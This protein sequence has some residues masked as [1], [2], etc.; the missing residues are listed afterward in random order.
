M[1]IVISILAA[2]IIGII[3]I[4]KIF[5]NIFFYPRDIFMDY[6]DLKK[7][8][9]IWKHLSYFLP[10]LDFLR[11]PVLYYSLILLEVQAHL[12]LAISILIALWIIN[13]LKDLFYGRGMGIFLGVFL[14]VNIEIFKMVTLIYISLLFLSRYQSVASFLT[15]VTATFAV[16][17][18]VNYILVEL[19]LVILFSCI[20]VYNYKISFYQILNKRFFHLFS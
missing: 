14:V 11:A 10:L 5:T 17:Y 15:G 6:Y 7:C 3:P 1:D 18:S 9:A 8:H 19:I 4:K 20:V 13:P 16:M 12:L 2:L